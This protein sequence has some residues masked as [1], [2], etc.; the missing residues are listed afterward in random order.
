MGYIYVRQPPGPPSSPNTK[1]SQPPSPPSQTR[2]IQALTIS[3]P[4]SQKKI[5]SPIPSPREAPTPLLSQTLRYDMDGLG[6]TRRYSLGI[7]QLTG[8]PTKRDIKIEYR[9]FAIIYHPDKHNTIS[10]GMTSNQ[11]EDHFKKI[12]SAYE[13]LISQL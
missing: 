3:P 8:R 5:P 2:P 12:N 4:P 7:L 10:T 11:E 1:R 13:Y 6:K 9:R